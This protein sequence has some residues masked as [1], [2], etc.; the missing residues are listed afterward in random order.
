MLE[1]VTPT[2]PDALD[3]VRA[4]MRD[5]VAWHRQRHAAELDLVD[6]YFDAAAFERELAGLPGAY[7]PPDGALLLARVDGAPAGCVGL[8]RLAPDCAE[9]KRMFVRPQ[10]HGQGVG[11]ALAE[12]IL[13]AASAAGYAR[14]RLDTGRR[15][16]EAQALYHRLGFTPIAPYYPLPNAVRDWLVF[17]ERPLTAADA[18]P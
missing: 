9:M 4:L 14:M 15:Q 17:M 8:R 16:V 13:A 1:I 6:A 3:A 12:A 7:G 2:S 11:R 10:Y 18:R 5:F